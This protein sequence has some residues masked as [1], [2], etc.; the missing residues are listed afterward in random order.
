MASPRKLS[1]SGSNILASA[2]CSARVTP[3]EQIGDAK[4]NSDIQWTASI[5][6]LFDDNRLQITL[7]PET[8]RSSNQTLSKSVSS[9]YCSCF[10]IIILNRNSFIHVQVLIKIRNKKR[11]SKNGHRQWWLENF[12]Y[13]KSGDQFSLISIMFIVCHLDLSKHWSE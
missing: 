8:T 9:G 11:Y 13:S 1:N 5:C 4:N 12:F 2:R 10:S 3:L 7:N 6:L